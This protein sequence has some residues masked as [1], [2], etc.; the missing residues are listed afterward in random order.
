MLNTP[1]YLICC[2]ESSEGVTMKEEGKQY[3]DEEEEGWEDEIK[4]FCS[5]DVTAF[6]LLSRFF[7]TVLFWGGESMRVCMCVWE[8]STNSAFDLWRGG[9]GILRDGCAQIV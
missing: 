8:I 1:E 7:N 9:D 3:L 5:K 2:E 6:N 4:D